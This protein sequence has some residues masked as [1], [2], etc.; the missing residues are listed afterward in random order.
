MDRAKAVK[1][2]KDMLSVPGTLSSL[3]QTGIVA[4]SPKGRGT[5]SG[6]ALS[7]I[8]ADILIREILLAVEAAVPG[9][10][11]G[12]YGDNL[13][14]IVPDASQRASVIEAL[15]SAVQHHVGEDVISGLTDRIRSTKPSSW[16]QFC[17]VEYRWSRSA[18]TQRTTEE[19]MDN[20]AVRFL[21]KVSD[22]K[23]DEDYDGLRRSLRSWIGQYQQLPN[24]LDFALELAS[25]LP[26]TKS[27]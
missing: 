7:Q 3:P 24:A 4:V 14:F 10:R 5:P 8:A 26:P 6:A 17:G 15:T 18:L 22:A 2:S 19:R 11:A 13:I 27:G 21:T 23:T 25:H 9:V 16:F 20:Y 12:A 1:W